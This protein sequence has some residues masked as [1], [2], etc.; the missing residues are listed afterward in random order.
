MSPGLITRL[1]QSPPTTSARRLV[2]A[3][4]NWDAVINE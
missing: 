2:P 4:T 3:A 1:L